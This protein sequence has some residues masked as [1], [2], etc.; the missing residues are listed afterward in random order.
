MAEEWIYDYFDIGA[1][2]DVNGN[3]I[4]MVDMKTI[5]KNKYGIDI[6]EPI[7]R[8]YAVRNSFNQYLF[9][10]TLLFKDMRMYRPLTIDEL[11]EYKTQHEN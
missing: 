6:L 4:K 2:I 10:W 9:R 11:Q 7:L 1:E 8:C 5:Y 3:F